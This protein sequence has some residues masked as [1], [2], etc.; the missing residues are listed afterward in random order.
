MAVMTMSEPELVEKCQKQIK[1][2][3]NARWKCVCEAC[4]V[5]V[6]EVSTVKLHMDWNVMTSKRHLSENTILFQIL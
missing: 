5:S 3:K 6:G 4:D 1:Q 2:V